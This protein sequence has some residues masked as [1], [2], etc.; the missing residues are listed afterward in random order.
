MPDGSLLNLALG[1]LRTAD[2]A[3]ANGDWPQ[4]YENARTAA[5]LA[6]KHVLEARGIAWGKEHNV[7][8]KLTRAG[9]WPGGAIGTRLS[10]FLDDATRGVYG[11]GQ[12]VTRVEAERGRKMAQ[13]VIDVASKV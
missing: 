6:A 1:Y 2:A 9:A 8:G 12:A 10:K 11:V 5:E 3:L 13:D 7:A 4:A